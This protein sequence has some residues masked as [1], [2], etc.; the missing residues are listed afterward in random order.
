VAFDFTSQ[1]RIVRGR[2]PTLEMVNER[3]ARFF[4][5]SLLGLMQ[6][7]AEVTPQGI[8]VQKYSEYATSLPMP[9]SLS[10]IELKPLQGAG[11]LMIDANLVFTLVD[12]FFGGNGGNVKIEERNFTAT[13]MRVIA[14]VIKASFDNLQEAWQAVV[15]LQPILLGNEDNPTLS[16]VVSPD[17]AM[18]VSTFQVDLDG[19]SGEYHIALPVSMLEPIKETLDSGIQSDTTN[20]DERWTEV[21]KDEL[22][23]ASVAINCSVVEKD[24]ALRDII[25]LQEGDVIPIDMPETVRVLASGTP[26]LNAKLGVSGEKLAL[27]IVDRVNSNRI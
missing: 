2:M 11:L 24:I 19:G 4:R 22:L 25:D 3:F 20:K 10:W 27:Q 12:N 5:P 15:D 9:A 13:E 21:L 14:R 6:R 18:V 1:G 8:K 26:V 23:Y 16:N 7:G 17:E